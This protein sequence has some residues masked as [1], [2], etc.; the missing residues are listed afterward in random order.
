MEYTYHLIFDNVA[1]I[2]S[3]FQLFKHAGYISSTSKYLSSSVYYVSN[4]VYKENNASLNFHKFI[5]V[6][7]IE[8]YQC[9]KVFDRSGVQESID[10]LRFLFHRMK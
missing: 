1:E 4:I 7:K 5:N 8:Y 2:I 3:L 6:E 9:S 10:E